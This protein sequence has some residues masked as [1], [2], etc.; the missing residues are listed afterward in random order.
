MNLY[1]YLP[2]PSAHSSGVTKSTIFGLMSRYHAQ[3]TY[4]KDY[5]HFV[6][7]LYTHLLERGWKKDDIYDIFLDSASTIESRSNK[8]RQPKQNSDLDTMQLLHLQFNPYDVSK[9][10]IRQLYEKHCGKLFSDEMGIERF[11]IA[12]SHLPNIGE[13][14]TQAK[15]HEAPGQTSA[16]IMGEYKDGMSPS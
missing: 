5:L 16:I 6:V 13:Y 15:L 9:R 4:R 1:L 11:V 2:P 12:Y 14:I 10:E 3:N 7:R 8:P